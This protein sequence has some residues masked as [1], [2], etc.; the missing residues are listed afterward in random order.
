MQ[1]ED[2]EVA[3]RSI[4]RFFHFQA[5]HMIRKVRVFLPY[6]PVNGRHTLEYRHFPFPHL[7]S[8]S[9]IN[10]MPNRLLFIL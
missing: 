9:V 1:L 8:I 7:F 6:F 5:Q 2:L 10:R 3:K 4:K